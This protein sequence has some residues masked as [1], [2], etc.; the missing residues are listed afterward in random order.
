M[1]L[2]F[3][4]HIIPLNDKS[5]FIMNDKNDNGTQIRAKEKEVRYSTNPFV[6]D[7][8]V[9]TTKKSIRVNPMG[10][11]KEDNVLVDQMTGEVRGT[12]VS[13][14]KKLIVKIL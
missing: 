5:V 2:E 4:F 12:H 1:T 7:L 10:L 8:V 6:A 9:N 11:G 13:T 14:Y 3:Y